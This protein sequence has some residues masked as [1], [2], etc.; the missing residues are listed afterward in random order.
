[1]TP[2]AGI[3]LTTF[4]AALVPGATAAQN[5][6]AQSA[7]NVM[8]GQQPWS[9]TLSDAV[10]G[11]W[12]VFTARAGRSYC[13]EMTAEAWNTGS[14]GPSDTFVIVYEADGTTMITSNDDTQ[15]EPFSGENRNV[16]G[17]GKGLS[18]A[19]F[20]APAT[21][22]VPFRVYTP[23]PSAASYTARVVETTLFSNWF[24]VGGDYSAFTLIRNTTSSSVTY[25]VNWRDAS[26]AIVGTANGTVAADGS[27]VL[28][29]R[30]VPAAVTAGAGT[31]EIVHTASPDAIV[32]ST[33][34]LSATTGLSFDAPFSKRVP[35]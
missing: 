25:K 26:G 27:A 20:V 17:G 29:A 7:Q 23:D 5:V 13:I 1:M 35:W 24:F 9:F 33:T 14:N 19:C 4:V 15:E 34:V 8:V 32:A 10:P 16:P 6:D 22:S 31:V 28:N 3:F 18:R 2:R 11:R 21:A 30:S 12:Y